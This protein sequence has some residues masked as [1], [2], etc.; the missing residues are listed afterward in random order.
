MGRTRGVERGALLLTIALSLP[1]THPTNTAFILDAIKNSRTDCS[2]N[3]IASASGYPFDAIIIPGAGIIRNSVGELEPSE[4]GKERLEAGAFARL[5]GLADNIIIA[6]GKGK[7]EEKSVSRRYLHQIAP[8]I[9]DEA[10]FEEH[11][12]I[13]TATDMEES[14][15]IAQRHNFKLVAV[16]TNASHLLRATA[17]ACTHGLKAFPL[18][19]EELLLEKDPQRKFSS[20]VGLY[21][22]LKEKGEVVWMLLDPQA[23][24]LTTA[25]SIMN[26]FK[27]FLTQITTS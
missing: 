21:T 26:S 17:L 3:T 9:P 20:E 12:S 5:R 10:I 19:A 15:K 23:N 1:I 7:P 6:D 11:E 8:E 24:T 27:A 22:Q 18:S 25:R 13:N 16:L 2:G 4:K 14:A